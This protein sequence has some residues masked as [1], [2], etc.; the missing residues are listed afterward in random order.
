[1]K[2]RLAFAVVSFIVGVLAFEPMGAR[3]Q[4]NE[5]TIAD[6]TWIVE[7]RRA[8]V[9][10]FSVNQH[11]TLLAAVKGVGSTDKGFRV[12][13]VNAEDVT[14]CYIRG[15]ICRELLFWAQ[16][17]TKSFLRTDRIPSGNWAF[18]VENQ[19]NISH[20]MTVR[21]FMSVNEWGY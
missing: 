7:A 10:T 8:H 12:R 16:D 18:L 21:V 4:V 13:V 9:Q 11:A 1:M 15:G 17:A 20:R 2:N 3:A 5:R 19:E 14:S 6:T